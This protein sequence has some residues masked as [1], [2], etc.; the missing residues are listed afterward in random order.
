VSVI[1]ACSDQP[2]NFDI[3]G[4]VRLTSSL[5]RI[6]ERLKS[7]IDTAV[8]Q[9]SLSYTCAENSCD[10]VEEEAQPSSTIVHIVPPMHQGVA[11]KN[12]AIPE[13]GS[14]V[15]T[16]WHVGFDSLE[17]YAGERF[18]VAWEDFRGE[19]T[20]V[21]SKEIMT[22]RTEKPRKGPERK[23]SKLQHMVKIRLEN[24]EYPYSP[25][26][27]AVEQKLSL[28]RTAYASTTDAA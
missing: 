3:G 16:M 19:W 22:M 18:E 11:E 14:W 15:I 7:L 21:Y 9:N 25:L 24:Q 1:L 4:L 23:V 13:C 17:R 10:T 12:L 2:I 5:V 27:T 8:L 28:I 26:R 20:R 6:E